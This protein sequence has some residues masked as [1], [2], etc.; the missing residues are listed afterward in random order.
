MPAMTLHGCRVHVDDSGGSGPAVLLLH[1]FLFDG[2]MFDAQVATLRE[3][4]RCVTMDFRGQGRSAP[5]RAGFQIE[6][7]AADVTTLLRRLD[8]PAVHLVGL[9]M[10][11]YVAMRIAARQPERVQSLSL[12]NTGAGPHPLGKYP[13][14]VGLA[15]T[16]RMLGL[17]RP[18]VAD[19][20]EKA[21]F[22]PS[23]VA[24]PS[25]RTVREV[26]RGRWAESD[27][28]S[29]VRTLS[30]LMRRPDV[31]PELSDITAP[32]LVLTGGVDPQH[33]P[34][35][36]RQIVEGIADSSYVEVPGVGHTATI[37]APAA[38]SDAV[39]SFITARA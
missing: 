6:Q 9:S 11:G 5:C 36:S 19:A 38:V 33:P 15:A 16:V 27:V 12:L 14:H 3:R 17:A 24:D 4:F 31:R 34:A 29:L 28:P 39:G 8:L 21:M 18:R 37:E 30:G 2:R 20:V 35:D 1:G 13:E 26:W 32:T 10:G 25:T 23:F 22:G 7:Q